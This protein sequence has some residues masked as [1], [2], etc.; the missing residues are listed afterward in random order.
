VKVAH[1]LLLFWLSC[2]HFS[3]NWLKPA[4]FFQP[5]LSQRMVRIHT[6]PKNGLK[7]ESNRNYGKVNESR[8]GIKLFPKGAIVGGQPALQIWQR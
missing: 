6:R 3:Q 8:A 2:Q 1:T 5:A 4:E 7:K